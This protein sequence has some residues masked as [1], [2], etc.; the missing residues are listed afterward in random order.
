[1]TGEIRGIGVSPGVAIG[2]AV[3]VL[4]ESR[5]L[6]RL[7]LAPE[8]VEAET[9][10]FLRAVEASRVQLAGIKDRLARDVG[11]AH[12]YIFDAHLLM[13]DDPLFRDRALSVMRE[14]HVNAE[15]ALRTVAD[16]L[17]D[18]FARLAD[19]YFRERGT[20]L[21][22]V[23]GRVLLNL[24]GAGDA[25]SLTRLPGSFV[26]VAGG[27]A[28][29]EAAELDWERVLAV[30]TDEGSATYHTSILARSFGVPAVV[31]L[32]DATRRIAPGTTVVVDGTRGLV[33]VEPSAPAL[34]GFRADRERERAEDERLQSLRT[35]PA[36]TL[37]GRAVVLRANVEFPDDAEAA[38]EHGAEGIGLFRSEYLLGRARDWPSEER[39]LEVYGR[40]LAQVAPHPVTVRTW[41]VGLADLALGGPSCAN[42]ALGERALRLLPRAPDAFHRQLRALL[43][44]A[45]Q[46]P[47]RVLFPFVSGPADL[48][49]AQSLI[50]AARDSLAAEGVLHAPRIDLGL[51][52]EVPSAALTADLLARGADFFAIG[53]N[54]LVQYLLAADRGDPRVAPHYQPLHPAVLRLLRQVVVA[55]DRAAI[56]VSVCGQMAA[57]VLPALLLVGLGVR[58]LSMNPA[59][60]PRVKAAIRAVRADQLDGLARTCLDLPTADEIEATLRRALAEVLAPAPVS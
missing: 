43:R 11:S 58:E 39:Q 4:R 15:W 32:R 30:A 36:V 1:V 7:R 51:N 22:D 27:L 21:D 26:L 5:P 40:L 16:E 13:L 6:V 53:T 57:D 60:I 3:V 9:E 48:R 35:L 33:V 37:D 8:A 59:A 49:L 28:P 31:G 10:R 47:L 55:A 19:D 50:A 25:P 54:D 2:P 17:H 20:D 12:G 38:R 42:P 14:E 44:A 29:S 41:D 56:P 24:G 52:L 45:L 46:G 23:V 34:A 18:R